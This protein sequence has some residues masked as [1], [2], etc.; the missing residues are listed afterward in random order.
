MACVV[1]VL[2]NLHVMV[3]NYL[4]LC[5]NSKELMDESSRSIYGL[6]FV[7]L[8]GW[9]MD[10]LYFLESYKMSDQTVEEIEAL[11]AEIHIVSMWRL[12]VRL[13]SSE[14][15]EISAVQGEGILPCSLYGPI[16]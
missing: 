4:K 6:D 12:G 13:N 10:W 9:C 11:S 8:N 2:E 16:A 3:V 14:R 7:C 1:N 15:L 5:E